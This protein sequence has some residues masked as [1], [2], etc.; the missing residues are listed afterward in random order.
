MRIPLM[1]PILNKEMLNCAMEALKNEKFLRG[2]SVEEFEDNFARYIGV[3]HAIALN[4]GTS[5]LHLSLI[6][7]GIRNGDYV[8]TT[9]ATF[10]ATANVILF[11]NAKPIFVD[12]S[13]DTY[14]IN[15]K[16]LEDCVKKYKG[17]VKAVSYT[18]LTLPTN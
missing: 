12:I 7:M 17:K 11:L 2:K 15:V 18:H 1:Q 3:K 16:Q 5:A 10:V 9:P 14:T 6:A 4:S 13:L 8:I